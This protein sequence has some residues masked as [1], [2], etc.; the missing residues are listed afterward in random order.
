MPELGDVM[1]AQS[2]LRTLLHRLHDQ[3]GIILG[4][5]EIP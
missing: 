4:E 5:A 3:R 1:L 2:E